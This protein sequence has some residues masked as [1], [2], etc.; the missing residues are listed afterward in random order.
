[1]GEGM[2][3]SLYS[4]TERRQTPRTRV[5]TI[6]YI[7]FVSN[8]GGILSNISEG[9]L[10]FHAVGPVR[11]AEELRVWFSADGHRIE[12]NV[13]LAWTDE[14][15]KTGGLRF[16]A[17]SPEMHEQIRNLIRKLATS[18]STAQTKWVPSVPKTQPLS[19]LSASRSP[20]ISAPDSP[21]SLQE[22]SPARQAALLR[23]GFFRGLLAGLLIAALVA[24]AVLLRTYRRQFGE[25]LI[26]LGERFGAKPP[27][28]MVSLPAPIPLP[29]PERPS[30]P[31]TGE[32][33]SQEAKLEPAAPVTATS[34]TS[35][36]LSSRRVA[37]TLNAIPISDKL[38][39]IPQLEPANPPSS[40][41]RISQREPATSSPSEGLPE[42][43][44]LVQREAANHSLRDA[45][46][47]APP[48]TNSSAGK[49]FDAGKFRDEFRANQ[50][51]DEFGQLG[52]HAIIVHS[53]VL[54]MNS[55]HILVGPYINQR[56]IETARHNLESRGFNPRVLQSRSKHF[57]LPP[58][59]LYGT[60]LTVRDCIITWELNSPDATVDFMQGRNVVATSKGRWEKRGFA[61]KTDALVSRENERGP[62][63]LLEIQRAGMD[64]GLVLDGSVLRVYLDRQ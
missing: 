26:Q 21:D 58:M 63:T 25:S 29:R 18:L 52:F 10:C 44:G 22:F 40:D 6:T 36:V 39:K 28:Q 17:L 31:L 61:F 60:D 11:Q 45:R 47:L 54:W 34:P 4:G 12:A 24:A 55:Y 33:K 7:N 57:S 43:V 49:Y 5:G 1:M 59:T 62:A 14:T 30:V 23:P 38:G 20:R 46:D 50:A 37:V 2:N 3:A 35:P 56:E 13:E 51:R 27:A 48:Y 32:V 9:G 64:Q 16:N 19:A 42:P 53:R 8:N 15:Q 41:V